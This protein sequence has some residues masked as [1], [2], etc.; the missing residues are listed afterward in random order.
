M[1][2]T[3]CGLVRIFLIFLNHQIPSSLLLQRSSRFS[4]LSS[5]FIYN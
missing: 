1:N 2:Y 5:D 4:I 3:F